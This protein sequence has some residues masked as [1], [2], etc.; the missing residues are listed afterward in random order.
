ML[1]EGYP[2]EAHYWISAPEG[3]GTS[4][5]SIRLPEIERLQFSLRPAGSSA[6][7]VE[8]EWVRLGFD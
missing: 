1:P 6:Q 8:I 4:G 3:R 2:G 7:G 5:D